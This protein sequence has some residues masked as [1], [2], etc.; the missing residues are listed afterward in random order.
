[1]LVL[2]LIQIRDW[3]ILKHSYLDIVEPDSAECKTHMVWKRDGSPQAIDRPKTEPLPDVILERY[4]WYQSKRMEL[5]CKFPLPRTL[6]AKKIPSLGRVHVWTEWR[7]ASLHWHPTARSKSKGY[8]HTSGNY[9]LM[10]GFLIS[11]EHPHC[12]TLNHPSIFYAA[13]LIRITGEAEP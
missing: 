3:N 1:M 12:D 2:W 7:P 9:N 11:S 4:S 8:I 10:N 13:Y 5:V 6:V